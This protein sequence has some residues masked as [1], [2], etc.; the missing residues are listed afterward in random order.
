MTV[1][2]MNISNEEIGEIVKSN[3][4]MMMYFELTTQVKDVVNQLEKVKAN[5][6]II[7]S[8]LENQENKIKNINDSQEETSTKVNKLEYKIDNFKNDDTGKFELFKATAKARVHKLVGEKGSVKYILFYH[9]FALKIY[10]DIYNH[11]GANNSGNIKMEF[12][13][14]SISMESTWKPSMKYV[15]SKL[16]E[17]RKMKDGERLKEPKLTAYNQYMSETEGGIN[18]EF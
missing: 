13:D 14:T 16:N 3:P 4:S 5:Q 2:I 11:F 18:I 7:F 10:S 6:D 15:K 9:S 17:Y 12:A 8:K 1:D